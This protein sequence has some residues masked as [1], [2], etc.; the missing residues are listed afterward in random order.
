VA[1]PVIERQPRDGEDVRAA[2]I[3]LEGVLELDRFDRPTLGPEPAL[4]RQLVAVQP[5]ERG[6][7][8]AVGDGDVRRPY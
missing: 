6:R 7:D 2:R 5:R 4:V 1:L 8:L 3:E